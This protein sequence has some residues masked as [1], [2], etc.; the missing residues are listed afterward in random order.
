MIEIPKFVI[1]EIVENSTR[2]N[3]I[4]H[5]NDSNL[6]CRCVYIHMKPLKCSVSSAI[7]IL[8]SPTF[9]SEL[10]KIC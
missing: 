9:L 3:N 8:E 1:K 6:S 10:T 4:T 2:F 7:L 5:F